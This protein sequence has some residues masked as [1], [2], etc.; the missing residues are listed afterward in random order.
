[1]GYI[2]CR[3]FSGGR[4]MTELAENQRNRIFTELRAI[5]SKCGGYIPE[6]ELYKLAAKLQK[7]DYNKGQYIGGVCDV[8][9]VASFYPEFRFKKPPK[10]EVRVCTALPCYLKGAE[11][12]YRK[13]EK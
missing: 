3:P 6:V 13:I 10:V 2:S 9:S 4:R 8:Y 5:Q 12:E 1:M 7:L 11:A